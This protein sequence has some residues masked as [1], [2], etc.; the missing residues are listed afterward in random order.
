ML[1]CKKCGHDNAVNRLYCDNCGA[2]LEHN[3]EDVRAAVDQEIKRDKARA[4]SI[5]IRW[6]LGFSIVVLLVGFLFRR[7]YKDLPANDIV[8]FI[9]APMVELGEP[10]IYTT[11][12]F[13]PGLPAPK[14]APPP[15]ATR[16]AAAFKAEVAADAFRRAAVAIHPKD[17]KDR[18][19]GIIVSDTVQSFIPSGQS[20]PC[21]VHPADIATLRTLPDGGF[22][23]TLRSSG[24]ALQGTFPA[25]ATIDLHVLR[26]APDGTSATET[27]PLRNIAAIGPAEADNP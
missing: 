12:E 8:P 23:L 6:F 7:A 4:T 22:G 2:E 5:G 11:A 25:A 13:G 18:I 21:D 19:L 16:P 26:R 17:G 14:L 20:E 24:K 3:L 27:L 1:L 9:A 10:P 15:R